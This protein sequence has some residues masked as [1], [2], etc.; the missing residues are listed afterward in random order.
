MD[1]NQI[2]KCI[3]CH[4]DFIGLKILTMF[5]KCRKGII[6]YHKING[7]TTMKKHVDVDCYAFMKRLVEDPN[8]NLIK[9]AFD[10]KANKKGAHVSLFIIFTLFLKFK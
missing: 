2:M 3:I 1:H 7:I 4:N 9:T 8:I 5:T 6:T 10:R